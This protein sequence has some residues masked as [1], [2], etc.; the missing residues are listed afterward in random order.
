MK[1]QRN[2]RLTMEKIEEAG[3]LKI[4][5]NVSLETDGEELTREGECFSF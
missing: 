2:G 4:V 1:N 3:D 5:E